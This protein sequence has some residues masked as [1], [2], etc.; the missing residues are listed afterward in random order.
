[1]LKIRLKRNGRQHM[2]IYAIVLMESLTRREG[3]SIAELG[4]YEPAT[5][6]IEIN[7]MELQKRLSQGARP[8]KTVRHL[9]EKI[10][11]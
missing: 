2:P 10:L 3:K 11:S 4:Y 7:K 6:R 8:T 1:M 5:K 9:I